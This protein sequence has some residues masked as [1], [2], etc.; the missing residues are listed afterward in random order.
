M[1]LI[2]GVQ[3]VF[4]SLLIIFLKEKHMWLTGGSSQVFNIFSNYFYSKKP[5]RLTGGTV[6]HM[7]SIHSMVHRGRE[8]AR[9]WL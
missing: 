6:V 8:P 9:Q 4:F 3:S 5:E 7:D 1:Q 2:G